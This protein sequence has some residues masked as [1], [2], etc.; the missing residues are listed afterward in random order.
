[1]VV[2]KPFGR[3][4]A[5]SRELQR[6]I[7]RAFPP[8]QVYRIDHFLGKEP[9]QNIVYFRFANSLLEPVWNC[10]Y[11]QSVQITMAET[12]GVTGRGCFYDKVGCLRDVIQNHAMQVIACLAMDA[13]PRGDV[14]VVRE[15]RAR[16][17]RAIVPLGP[18]DVVRGQFAGYRSEPGVAP[19]SHTET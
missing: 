13:P 1:L 7:A 11:V 16:L 2:E 15:E 3:D 4:L 18:R 19:D 5:S 10:H 9:V 12:L 14:D 6:S 17:L 8:E